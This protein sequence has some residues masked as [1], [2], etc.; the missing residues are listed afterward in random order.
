MTENGTKR[1]VIQ[2][3]TDKFGRFCGQTFG[4][5]D[6]KLKAMVFLPHPNR[7]KAEAYIAQMELDL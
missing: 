2:N 3:L 1:L 5:W 7:A 4:V 6:T